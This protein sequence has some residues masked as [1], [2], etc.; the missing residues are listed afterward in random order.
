MRSVGEFAN[1]IDRGAR[2]LLAGSTDRAG[3]PF[4]RLCRQGS[5]FSTMMVLRSHG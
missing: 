3:L 4:V 1:T 2:F 5:F